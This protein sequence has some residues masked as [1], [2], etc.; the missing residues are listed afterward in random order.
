MWHDLSWEMWIAVA[1]GVWGLAIVLMAPAV[2]YSTPGYLKWNAGPRDTDFDLPPIYGRLKRAYGNFM[3]S[4]V[5]FVV[6]AIA[7]ALAH[8]S[9][10]V[11]LFG[12]G[13]YLAARVIYVPLYAFGVTGWRSLAWFAGL[14]G[15][16][17]CLF[18][19]IF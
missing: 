17:A 8:R 13:L 11:S 14:A 18:A 3:E 16:A 4:Y 2:A 15:I 6:V 19:L 10:T 5:L 7:L 1:A 12:A 9:S